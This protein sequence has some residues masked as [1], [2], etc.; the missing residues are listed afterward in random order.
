MKESV[1][2][3]DIKMTQSFYIIYYK[4]LSKPVML[5]INIPLNEYSEDKIKSEIK[6][7]LESKEE[8]LKI[9]DRIIKEWNGKVVDIE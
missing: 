6:K 7:D 9:L 4:L 5:Q 8:Q 2:I 1:E 3:T